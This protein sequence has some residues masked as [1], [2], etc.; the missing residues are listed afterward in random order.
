MNLYD[1]LKE[2][3]PTQID[4]ICSASRT[5][6]LAHAYIVNSD[7]LDIREKISLFIAQL[8]AC[9]SK[10]VEGMPC[11]CCKICRQI[12]DRKFAELFE[13]SPVSKSRQIPI[14]DNKDD[15]GTMRWFQDCFYKSSVSGGMSK[16]GIIFDAD[17]LNHQAQNAFLKTLEE[18]PPKSIFIL[19]TANPFSMLPTIISRCH[20]INLLTNSCKYELDGQLDLLKSLMRLQS[21]ARKDLK[22]SEEVAKVLLNISKNL[23]KQAENNI[24][25]KWKVKFDEAE[26]PDFQYS[27][28]MKKRLKE[29]FEA[30]VASEYIRLRKVFLSMLHT[31]FA[32]GYQL[33]CGIE[34]SQ[35]ANS[36][37]YEHLDIKHSILDEKDAYKG[38]IKAEKLL[39]NLKWNVNEE[40]AFR[41]FCCSFH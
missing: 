15:Y 21:S 3:F 9:P 32:Q 6:K 40:L 8:S 28:V 19:N 11:G 13:L 23:T 31:W 20:N 14:G 29:K 26:N 41:E 17:C 30:A 18:P 5:G 35:L 4:L 25:P 34:I 33:A 27:S 12:I 10:L 36:E 2:F 24:L 38:L 1:E 7:S 37:I 39:Q 16:V 22:V